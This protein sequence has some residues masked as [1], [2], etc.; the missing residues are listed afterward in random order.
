MISKNKNFMDTYPLA[1]QTKTDIITNRCANL[2]IFIELKENPP[3]GSVSGYKHLFC[4]GNT[5]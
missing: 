2:Q 4:P 1:F 5:A 3:D